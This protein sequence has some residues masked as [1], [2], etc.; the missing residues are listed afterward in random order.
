MKRT[1]FQKVIAATA[2]IG[3]VI[4]TASVAQA[5]PNVHVSIGLPGLPVPV[6]LAPP[7][8]RPVFRA[9]PIYEQPRPIYQPAPVVV[10]ERPGWSS[11]GY[12]AERG[13]EWR[14][15]EWQRR[16][17]ERRHHRWERSPHHHGRD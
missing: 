6:F 11:Y 12:E 7:L 14:H 17:W 2:L 13:R 3:A 16:E 1:F 5:S 15:R 10:Y 9:E 4:G 8:P